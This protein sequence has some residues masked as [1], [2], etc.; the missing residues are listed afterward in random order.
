[1]FQTYCQPF[2]RYLPK[3]C[4]RCMMP[5]VNLFLYYLMIGVNC[6]IIEKCSK[7]GWYYLISQKWH[8]PNQWTVLIACSDWVLNLR[9]VSAIHLATFFW[10]SCPS[11]PSFLRKKGIICCWLS[12]GLVHTKTIFHISVGDGGLIF[13]LPNILNE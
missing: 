7:F 5:I 4:H 8:I 11:F 3:W 2:L 1:M 12:T 13:P 10:I 6:P 9:I